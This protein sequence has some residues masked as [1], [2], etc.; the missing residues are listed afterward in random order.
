MKRVVTSVVLGTSLMGALW[1]LRDP[2][3]L[4]GMSSGLRPWEERDGRRYRWSGGR[5]SFFV[6]TGASAIDIPIATTFTADDSRPMLV[7]V[8]IDDRPAGGILL[9]DP[10]WVTIHVPL[11]PP[12]SRRFRRIDVHTNITREDNHGVKIGE[13]QVIR[14]P[15]SA[16]LQ[17][18][19]GRRGKG[20][21]CAL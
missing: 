11:P 12:G 17:N 1:Y 5:A 19:V 7:S 10:E 8:T 21:P 20:Q 4:E 3:W 2:A 16:G 18:V 6:P 14:A 9:R 15:V 13:V